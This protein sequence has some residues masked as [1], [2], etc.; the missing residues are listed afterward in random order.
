ME[1]ILPQS[2][3]RFYTK[4]TKK[5]RQRR[6]FHLKNTKERNKKDS[7]H[8]DIREIGNIF[9]QIKCLKWIQDKQRKREYR[10]LFLS[11][12]LGKDSLEPKKAV[13]PRWQTWPPKAKRAGIKPM[14]WVTED[15]GVC[16]LRGWPESTK[17]VGQHR[18]TQGFGVSFCFFSSL[19]K[20]WQTRSRSKPKGTQKLWAAGGLWPAEILTDATKRT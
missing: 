6:A 3:L 11:S 20:V 16:L 19:Q 4:H 10:F 17:C 13:E 14:E 7:T 1:S 18:I 15:G 2:P 5:R 9:F 8:R 12:V